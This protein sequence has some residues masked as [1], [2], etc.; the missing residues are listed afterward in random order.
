MAFVSDI[1]GNIEALDAVLE[2]LKR[3]GVRDVYALGDHLLG[4]EE[5]LEVWRRLQS[6]DARCTIGPSD[7]ALATVDPD[8]LEAVTDDARARLDRFL[9]TRTAVGDLVLQQLRHLPTTLRVPMIDG[10]ELVMSHG[11]PADHLAEISHDL[12]E[13]EVL[14]LVDGD[15]ADLFICGATHVPFDRTIDDVRVVNVGSVGD[16]PEGRVAHYTVVTPA[17]E[18]ARVEQAWVEY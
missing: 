11:S 18:G 15:P 6:V 8:K 10:R 2:E 16:A 5:P 13:A 4:G 7:E 17:L 3:R 12:S 14:A 9:A 1:H